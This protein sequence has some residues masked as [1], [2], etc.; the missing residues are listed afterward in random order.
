M[1]LP[2]EHLLTISVPISMALVNKKNSLSIIFADQGRKLGEQKMF[3]F[4]IGFFGYT[5]KIRLFSAL[6]FRFNLEKNIQTKVFVS[7]LIFDLFITS[8]TSSILLMW[9]YQ[10]IAIV[11]LFFTPHWLESYLERELQR[12]IVPF[13]DHTILSIQTGI[14]LRNSVKESAQRFTGW[15][16]YELMK[17]CSS[18]I[19]SSN[20]I[21]LQSGVLRHLFDEIGWIDRGRNKTLEQLKSLRWHYK[22]QE[23]FRRKSGQISQQTRIQAA[24]MTILYLALLIFN[25]FQ[26]GFKEQL[27]LILFS[28]ALFSIGLI[29]VFTLGRRIKWK[30]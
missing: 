14:P 22:V 1:F 17:A 15:K 8:L 2:L 23:D 19:L 29:L 30:V 20:E 18:L 11:A 28:V 26:F 7:V 10:L 25:G 21:N 5:I 24:V 27:A 4:L 6:F 13:L 16:K 12:I 9:C 3:P